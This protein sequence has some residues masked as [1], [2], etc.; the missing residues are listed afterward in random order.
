MKLKQEL[1]KGL[2]FELDA[3]YVST[4]VEGKDEARSGRG[5]LLSSAY[6]YRPIDTPLGNGDDALFQMGSKN[7]EVGANPVGLTNAITDLTNRQNI[8]CK[9]HHT[10]RYISSCQKHYFDCF[11]YCLH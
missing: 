8:E 1:A 5:S 3:R 9:I 6:Q 10:H 4:N 2:S 7:I 11:H